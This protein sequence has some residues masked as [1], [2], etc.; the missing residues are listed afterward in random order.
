MIPKNHLIMNFLMIQHSKH[1]I[2]LSWQVQT[3]S[4]SVLW[5]EGGTH[6]KVLLHQELSL[7]K[8][9]T[10]NVDSDL[11]YQQIPSWILEGVLA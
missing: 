3:H 9:V 5:L 1:F 7:W 10:Y 11:V 6:T 2:F 8:R 4:F